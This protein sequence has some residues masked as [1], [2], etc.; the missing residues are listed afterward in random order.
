MQ[1]NVT[2]KILGDY[3]TQCYGEDIG[4]FCNKML[5]WRYWEIIQHN[6]MM[7]ILG[8]YATKCYDEDIGRLCN[9]M[10]RWRYWETMQHNA[11]MKS[12]EA[13]VSTVESWWWSVSEEEGCVHCFATESRDQY[14]GYTATHLGPLRR[15]LRTRHAKKDRWLNTYPAL[16]LGLLRAPFHVS[17]V[18]RL[19]YGHWYLYMPPDVTFRTEHE[20]W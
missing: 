15:V 1:Q 3:A 19:C 14:C 18:T 13:R 2:M 12:G 4:R 17:Q 20:H 8:D 11:T 9:T 5:R 16:V 7:K 6:V 10:L